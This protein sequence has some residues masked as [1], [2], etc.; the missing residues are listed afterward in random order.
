[1]S[2]PNFDD[3][4]NGVMAPEKEKQILK[5]PPLYAV[6][7][8]NDDYT[9]MEFVV[10]ILCRHFG[11]TEEESYQI[12]LDVHEK[13]KGIAAIYPK[14]IAETKVAIVRDEAQSE[15]HPLLLDIEEQD[16]E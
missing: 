1:M 11:K 2:E 13:G 7:L 14:D 3:G 8:L 6:V 9:T 16:S 10:D 15:G 5:R 12:M 4:D